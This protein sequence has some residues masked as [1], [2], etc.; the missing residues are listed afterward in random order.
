LNAFQD[1]LDNSFELV[2]PPMQRPISKEAIISEDGMYRY[3]LVRSWDIELPS[4]CFIMLNPSTAD[5]TQDDPTIRR[6]IAFARKW[7]F[8]TLRVVNLY[9]FRATDPAEL[10]TATDPVGPLNHE[11]LQAAVA[12][13]QLCIAAW[14]VHATV[15]RAA[16][17]CTVV[18][19]L[20]CL[21]V[22]QNGEPRH[23]LYVAGSTEPVPYAP[24][25]NAKV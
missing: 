8:G 9:A 20:K 22:T 13:S 18:N 25:L 2:P 21:G 10:K 3:L 7:G 11:Y 15:E 23:P 6:C 5:A 12:A 16:E 1:N 4:V 24:C 14:G 17:V 19:E